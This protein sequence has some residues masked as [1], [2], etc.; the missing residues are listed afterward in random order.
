MALRTTL[1]KGKSLCKTT[2]VMSLSALVFQQKRGGYWNGIYLGPGPID[3]DLTDGG[4]KPEG[5]PET[6]TSIDIANVDMG[7]FDEDCFPP[8]KEGET[9]EEYCR[10]VPNIW[11]PCSKAT[12]VVDIPVFNTLEW[13]LGPNPPEIGMLEEA[14]VKIPPDSADWH[15]TYQLDFEQMLKDIMFRNRPFPVKVSQAEFGVMVKEFEEGV[16]RVGIDHRFRARSFHEFWQ[17]LTGKDVKE[18]ANI[19]TWECCPRTLSPGA[20]GGRSS[21]DAMKSSCAP[22][23]PATLFAALRCYILQMERRRQPPMRASTVAVRCI[24]PAP[25]VRWVR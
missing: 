16:K 2:K 24:W 6:W 17:E 13:A 7:K 22:R 11:S 18:I 19:P 1:N 23:R 12:D 21:E 20:P 4:T 8:A 15:V 5:V 14:L 3:V 25:M 10:R 9:L